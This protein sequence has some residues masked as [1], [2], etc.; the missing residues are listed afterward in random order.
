M[1]PR[2]LSAVA[3]LA[4]ASS[5]SQSSSR[6]TAPAPFDALQ[7]APVVSYQSLKKKL[8]DDEA[9]VRRNTDVQVEERLGVPTFV[10]ASKLGSQEGLE[11]LRA[12]KSQAQLAQETVSD[13]AKAHFTHYSP[14]Y[15]L[16]AA[17]LA[18]AQVAQVHDLGT[19]AAI[20]Q[21]E[22]RVDGIEVFREQA[23]LALSRD[24]QLISIAG[25]LSP[26]GADQFKSGKT[27]ELDAKE[28][29]AVAFEDL[30]GTSLSRSTLQ[31]GGAGEG[32]YEAFTLAGSSPRAKKVWFHLPSQLLPAWYVEVE[33]GADSYSYVV[34]AVDSKVL[35]RNDLTADQASNLFQYRVWASPN[36]DPANP[37]QP[38]DG[39]QGNLFD[40]HPTGNL[41][42]TQF[43]G[44]LAQVDLSLVSSAYL[45]DPWLPLGATET[46]GNNV[47]AFLDL[48]T[49]DGFTPAS[50]DF[51]GSIT[52]PG[53]FLRTYNPATPI[54]ANER[55]AAITQLFYNVNFFHDWYYV[56]GFDEAAGNAQAN[57]YGRGGLGNDSI[58]G[59]GQD[60]S[61]RNN[62]N[63]NT[64]ADG[65]RPRMQMYLFDGIADRHLF[66][67]AGT[68]L[69]ADYTTGVP[70]G[71]GIATHDITADV[72]WVN[73]GVGSTTYPP[74]STAA[75]TVHDGC[76]A[77]TSGTWAGVAGKIAFID[78]GG[79][80]VAPAT[81]GFS[82]KA[83]NAQAAGAIGVII[84]S[85][86]PHAA[87]TPITMGVTGTP[88]VTIPAYQLS[89][90]DGDAFRTAMGSGTVTVHMLRL[91]PV[92]RDGT[93]DNQIM[94]HEWGH[95]IS[96]RLVQNSNGLTTNMARGMG[97]G[98]ADTHAMLLTVRADDRAVTYNASYGGV[99]G[100]ALWVETGGA[101]GPTA[102][103]GAYYGIRR[104]PYSTDLTKN[105][106]TYKNIQDSSAIP[107]GVPFSF[108]PAPNTTSANGGNSEVH[109]TG[110]VWAT[111]LWECYAA[112]LRDT[113]GPTPRLTFDQARNRWKDYLVAAYKL[114][115]GQPTFLE[116][117]DALLSAAY[118]R[119]MT[120]YH[121][122]A[123]AFAKR[124]AGFGAVSP[125]RYSATNN[126]VTESF[127][128]GSDLV[129]ASASLNDDVTHCD[130]DGVLDSGESGHLS[131]TLRN[132]STVRLQATTATVTAVGPNAGNVSFPGGNTLSFPAS[133]PR[134]LVTSTVGIALASGLSGVQVVDLQVQYGD[135]ALTPA[136][137]T[138]N[139]SRRANFDDVAS[140]SATDDVESSSP[141]FTALNLGSTGA[142][143]P[144]V[145]QELSPTD[146]NY[147]VADQNGNTDLALLSPALAVGTGAPFTMSFRHRYSFEFSGTQ[148]FDGAVVELSTD[149]G[150]TWADVT[151]LN[152]AV[153]GQ[154]Y[155]AALAGGTVLGTRQ[156]FGGINPGNP[157]FVTTSY[158]FGSALAGKSVRVRFRAASDSN[159]RA[160]GWEVDDIAFGGIVNLP[161]PKL[162][163]N[164]CTA[165]QTNRKP[166]ASIAAFAPM[167]E[168]T[169]GTLTGSAT[170]A[171]GDTLTYQWTQVSGVAVTLDTPNQAVTTFTAPDVP[172]AG[173]SAVFALTA[174][175][176]TAYSSPVTRTVNITNVDRAPTAAAGNDQTVNERVLVT[177][178]GSGSDPDGD[179][180]TYGWIQTAGPAV[181]LN[182]ATTAT[183]SFVAPDVTVGGATLSF[184]LTVTAGTLNAISTTNVEVQN[185]NQ[186]P[187]VNAGAA[188]AVDERTVVQLH[189]SALDPDGDAV[190]Y[191]WTQVSP[192][193]PVVTLSD[194]TDPSATFTAPE[195]NADTDFTFELSATDGIAP[196]VTAQVVVTVK[197][198]NR[199][200]V[201]VAVAPPTAN[202]HTTVTLDGAGS[203]DPDGDTLT[204]AW[205]V[206]GTGPTGSQLN[207][208][209]QAAATFDTGDVSADTPVTLTLTVSDGTLSST[210]TVVVN[211][212]DK[213]NAPV[214]VATGPA[215]ANSRSVVTLDGSGSTDADGNPLTY[216]WSQVAGPGVQLS[217]ASAIAPTFTAPQ[218]TTDTTVG[219][220]LTVSDG[221]LSN[222]SAPVSIV[223]HK[224]NRK[225]VANAGEALTV[226]EGAQVKLLGALSSDPDGDGLTYTWTQTAGTPSVTLSSATTANPT[227]TAP[228]VSADTELTF[229]LVV[230]DGAVDSDPATVVVTVKNVNSNT[231]PIAKPIAQ[232]LVDPGVK[233]TLDASGSSDPDGDPLTFKWKQVSGDTVTLDHD[234]VAKPAFT[235]PK[236]DAV[237]VL[238][239]E[240]TVTD[241]HSASAVA[242]EIITVK[243]TAPKGG[244]CGCGAVDGGALAMLGFGLMALRMRRRR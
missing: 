176:G 52:G 231:S 4:V 129:L 240:V 164:K 51:R 16:K 69:A 78:R 163:A 88:T 160:A 132:D 143:N 32:G 128:V 185:V 198:V 54:T 108:W 60:F 120:D 97:E 197:N 208:A 93:I 112:L 152:P 87:T 159:S 155:T 41:D 161:F 146:H 46:N 80:A 20:V 178:S 217:D 18:S 203:S 103:Q 66:V 37:S 187:T 190:T 48:V 199:A 166:V 183:P 191:T 71:W 170:D 109:N 92:D 110:E 106:M 139:V 67:T 192:A 173:G 39:P 90:P 12:G 104:M 101:N 91:A 31:G 119:D 218:V 81:C 236:K 53:Q 206:T 76:D 44:P 209:T 17:D 89:T 169:Q 58:R 202:E 64:P 127:V 13:A 75:A 228:D 94:A 184:Q 157:S 79:A 7:A 189:G 117:R 86:T 214:A 74:A 21:L 219:F 14:L 241:S 232:M 207:N 99:Y 147:Q 77:P 179:A 181:T 1:S 133:N 162:L 56:S 239:F 95:Y 230:N 62:A 234:D 171:D 165:A 150:N 61:G 57:N 158:N 224:D 19:G 2:V 105:N 118:G 235:A 135:T 84:A 5:C 111:M 3:L 34:S 227:F 196:A 138:V 23:R 186:A 49:P 151:T 220:V 22:Q 100:Q 59:E 168:R 113:T 200:P 221:S 43:P 42:G 144:W 131:L 30:S 145:R 167:P 35:Y 216:L 29:I 9:H 114:T 45:A 73:D 107:T 210:A 140:Q 149:N 175:D 70:S 121:L 226:D 182:N 233:V 125:D 211:V 177:L 8:A 204:Y 134:D 225:P 15:N 237:V 38:Y 243:P 212:L 122:F 27:F 47:D 10:W 213:N 142:L 115:P 193:T 6:A 65:A 28:A 205:A 63:M 215:S 244:G 188:K 201:A 26:T 126:G 68:G 136:T 153:T 24:H 25:F 116:A 83:V 124:G 123:A 72:V 130:T 222:T 238:D 229:S 40:P 98:Y 174:F 50:A 195:V 33:S 137:Y 223:I 55:N 11:Q 102:N 82:D 154:G 180:V 156:A 242:H 172:A 194:A 36:N 96:N 141:V 85:T 148:Y